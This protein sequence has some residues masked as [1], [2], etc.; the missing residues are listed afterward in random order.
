VPLQNVTPQNVTWHK[1]S[2]LQN[3]TPKNITPQNITPQNVTWHKTSPATKHHLPQN[4]TCHKTSPYLKTNMGFFPLD[5]SYI[6][7]TFSHTE[8]I[9][10]T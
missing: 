7:G 3:V 2:P 9:H 10:I 1:T 8:L 5:I 4:V 6:C